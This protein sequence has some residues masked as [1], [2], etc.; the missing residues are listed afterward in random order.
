MSV[1][2]IVTAFLVVVF[3]GLLRLR[4]IRESTIEDEIVMDK[5]IILLGLFYTISS[6]CLKYFRD[7]G[8]YPEAVIGDPKGLIELGYLK[9]E[10]LAQITSATKLFSMV[11]SDKGGVAVCL[12][13]ATTV[14]SNEILMKAKEINGPDQFVDYKSG[15]FIKLVYPVTRYT[16]NLSLPLPLSPI[17][18]KSPGVDIIDSGMIPKHT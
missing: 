13:H 1:I 15:Q 2:L 8:S 10:P 5:T 4:A 7:H 9:E 17:G 16:I 14:L 6:A 18:T 3:W 12:A 11:T